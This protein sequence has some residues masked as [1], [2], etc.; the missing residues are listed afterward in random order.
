MFWLRNKENNFPLHTL[1]WWRAY[2]G[3]DICFGK[4]VK[5]TLPQ[6][7]IGSKSTKIQCTPIITLCYT[8]VDHVTSQPCCKGIILQR[9]NKKM[10]IKW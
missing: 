4:F 6:N 5:Q 10:T 3:I 7:K 1:I 9:N 8:G 2:I